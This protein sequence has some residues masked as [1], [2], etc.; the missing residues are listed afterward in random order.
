[1]KE[2][3]TSEN[4]M[5]RTLTAANDNNENDD[6]LSTTWHFYEHLFNFIFIV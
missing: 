6:V 5:Q 4:E 2:R 3:K 1:M